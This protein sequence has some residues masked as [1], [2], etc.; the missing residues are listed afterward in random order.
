MNIESMRIK[1]YRVSPFSC[2]GCPSR[3]PAEARKL[4]GYLEAYRCP[5]ARTG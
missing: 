5:L 1:S 3:T 2:E 4:A